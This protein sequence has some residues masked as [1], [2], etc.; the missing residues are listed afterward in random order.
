MKNP[1]PLRHA[2]H[3]RELTADLALRHVPPRFDLRGNPRGIRIEA[4]EGEG[5]AGVRLRKQVRHHVRLRG[6]QRGGPVVA[7]VH[8]GVDAEPL[9]EPGQDTTNFK[10]YRYEAQSATPCPEDGLPHRL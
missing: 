6:V 7:G 9:P 8:A 3:L 5:D 1:S 2:V 4:G 10:A